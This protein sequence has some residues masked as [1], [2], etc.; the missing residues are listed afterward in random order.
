MFEMRNIITKEDVSEVYLLNSP[1]ETVRGSTDYRRCQS[2]EMSPSPIKSI[3]SR[4]LV[5]DVD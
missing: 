3:D 1:K 2:R 4:I 5:T